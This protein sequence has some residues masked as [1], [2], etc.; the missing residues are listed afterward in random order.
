MA[1]TVARR[2]REIG[3]RMALGAA[4]GARDLAGDERSAGSWWRSASESVCRLAWGLTGLV[5]GQGY[6][7]TPNDPASILWARLWQSLWPRRLAG[8]VP[9]FRAT[10]IEPDA[11]PSLGITAGV[12]RGR[13]GLF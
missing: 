11:R 3:V 4:A 7:I 1:Y 9:A 2:T 12:T 10:R 13:V 8:Y 6:G 5:N